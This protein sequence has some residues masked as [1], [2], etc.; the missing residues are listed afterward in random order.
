MSS[1]FLGNLTHPLEFSQ[2]STSLRQLKGNQCRN[3]DNGKKEISQVHSR[4]EAKALQIKKATGNGIQKGEEVASRHGEVVRQVPH[5]F[6][7]AAPLSTHASL[8]CLQQ[9]VLQCLSGRL[10]E[11]R[12]VGQPCAMLLC[13]RKSG[14]ATCRSQPAHSQLGCFDSQKR[15][16]K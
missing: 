6:G 3:F 1:R 13:V 15:K 10:G 8:Q 11:N 16:L 2:F 4:E 7:F 5:L 14:E 9:L 12:D